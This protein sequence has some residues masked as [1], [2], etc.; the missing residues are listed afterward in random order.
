MVW[1]SGWFERVT[2]WFERVLGWFGMVVSWFERGL[3]FFKWFG[4]GLKK[5]QVCL[6][7]F[8]SLFKLV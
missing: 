8:L 3:S 2:S 1:V 7:G 6:N 5:F 4:V